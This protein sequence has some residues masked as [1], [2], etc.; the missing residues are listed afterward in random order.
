MSG[1]ETPPVGKLTNLNKECKD[2]DSSK[3][4]LKAITPLLT[5][6][7]NSEPN[8]LRTIRARTC[9]RLQGSN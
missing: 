5:G 9:W 1:I 6:K 7:E 2:G 3:S 4:R 8:K